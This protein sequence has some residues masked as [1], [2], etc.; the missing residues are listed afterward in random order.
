VRTLLSRR[1]F[2]KTLAVAAGLQLSVGIAKSSGSSGQ[3][4]CGVKKA[5]VL[6]LI[7]RSEP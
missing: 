2:H 6:P 5:D 4:Y 3:S 7:R 1:D